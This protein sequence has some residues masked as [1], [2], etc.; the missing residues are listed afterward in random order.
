MSTYTL[1]IVKDWGLKIL[2]YMGSSKTTAKKPQNK[3]N[4]TTLFLEL[5]VLSQVMNAYSV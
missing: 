3:K 4:N 5:C 2:E 1:E